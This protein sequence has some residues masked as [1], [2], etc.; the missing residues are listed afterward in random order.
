MDRCVGNG[1]LYRWTS[2]AAP[3]TRISG[4][5]S[6]LSEMRTG[7]HIELLQLMQMMHNLHVHTRQ[8]LVLLVD[9]KIHAALL[10]FP[11]GRSYASRIL[12]LQWASVGL[13]YG[14]WH[15]YK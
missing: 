7:A 4:N 9:M 5:H 13:T 15:P 11:Y 14:I 12:A 10:R 8:D 6:L 3:C 1:L 2:Y